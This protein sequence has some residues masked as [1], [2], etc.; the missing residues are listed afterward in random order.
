[1]LYLPLRETTFSIDSKDRRN[2]N[3]V[4]WRRRHDNP[5]C[6]IRVERTGKTIP[7]TGI[8]STLDGIRIYWAEPM[9]GF[10]GRLKKSRYTLPCG[11]KGAVCNEKE[12]K[13]WSK[14]AKIKMPQKPFIGLI[15]YI[16]ICS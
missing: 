13:Y 10:P 15:V 3:I 1:M 9:D 7:R 6:L 11:F 8:A 12:M 4:R 14:T 16:W 2:L 5:H